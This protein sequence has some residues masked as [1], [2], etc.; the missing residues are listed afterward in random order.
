MVH[1]LTSSEKLLGRISAVLAAGLLLSGC[2]L[3]PQAPE[4]SPS[5]TPPIVVRQDLPTLTPTLPGGL[6]ITPSP[7]ALPQLL[8]QEILGPVTV[9]GTVHRTQEP[10]TVRVRYGKSVSKPTCSFILQDTSQT[11]ALTGGSTTQI[12]ANTNED[13]YSF[14]PAAAGTYQVNCT[15]IA[16]TASGQRAVSAAGQPFAVEAKG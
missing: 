16:L 5:P 3:G 8:P 9:D 4:A 11:T 15:G 2:N 10:V 14:T 13:V 7:T 12:D 1:D 6:Q